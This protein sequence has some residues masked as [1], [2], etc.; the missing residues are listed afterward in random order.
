MARVMRLPELMIGYGEDDNPVSAACT[1]C[2]QWMPENYTSALTTT[3]VIG[4]F[5][6]HFLNHVLEKHLHQSSYPTRIC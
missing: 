1:L 3:E 2:G 6:L 5:N 4:Y